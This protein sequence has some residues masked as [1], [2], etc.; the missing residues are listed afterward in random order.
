MKIIENFPKSATYNEWRLMGELGTI[1]LTKERNSTLSLKEIIDTSGGPLK[2]RIDMCFDFPG[3]EG[4]SQE[5]LR[6]GRTEFR[7]ADTFGRVRHTV[8][9]TS[10][11][12]PYYGDDNTLKINSIYLFKAE[13]QLDYPGDKIIIF[14]GI[15]KAVKIVE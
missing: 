4:G 15:T 11:M 3:V 10:S 7:F 1:T 2:Y 14:H 13:V 6:E 5:N 12:C 8:Q 9:P